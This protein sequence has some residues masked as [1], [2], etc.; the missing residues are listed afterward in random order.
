MSSETSPN[1]AWSTSDGARSNGTVTPDVAVF[2]GEL[3]NLK[4]VSTHKSVMLHIEV[5]EE[6]G[7]ALVAAFGW[8]TRVKPVSVAV[9]RLEGGGEQ[10]KREPEPSASPR[11]FESLTPAEQ[12]GILCKEPDFDR[13][14]R[15]LRLSP[16][17]MDAAMTVR[18]I[19]GVSSR[20]DIMPGTE[21]EQQWRIIYKRF[22]QWQDERDRVDVDF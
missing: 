11:P 15:E 21:A 3:V 10:P 4:N 2:Q 22:R 17:G 8:P 19:C 14:V 1:P 9:A 12:A 20:A 16:S 6:Y 18:S 7:A 5:P 13:F